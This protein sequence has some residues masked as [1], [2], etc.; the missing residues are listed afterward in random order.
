MGPEHS[1]TSTTF[2]PPPFSVGD[3]SSATPAKSSLRQNSQFEKKNNEAPSSKTASSAKPQVLPEIPTIEVVVFGGEEEGGEGTKVA[4]T[5]VKG[6]RFADEVDTEE[7]SS[8]NA[9]EKEPGTASHAASSGT[10]IDSETTNDAEVEGVLEYKAKEDLMDSV[11][12]DKVTGTSTPINEESPALTKRGLAPESQTLTPSGELSSTAEDR[13]EVLVENR[14][15]GRENTMKDNEKS[16]TPQ[17]AEE[18]AD[19]TQEQCS[20]AVSEGDKS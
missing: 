5:P 11:D 6:V 7:N 15:G 12:F 2:S 20:S 14:G 18:S 17:D 4:R 1:P 9:A 10:R 8:S 13:E 16:E 3:T 19:E